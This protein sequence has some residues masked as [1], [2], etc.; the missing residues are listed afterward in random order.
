MMKEKQPKPKKETEPLPE[1]A[2][3]EQ[4]GEMV[5]L[6]SRMI[7]ILAE[8][9]TIPKPTTP[10]R[11]PLTGSIAAI[12]YDLRQ[13]ANGMTAEKSRDQA[14][15]AKADADRAELAAAKEKGLLMLV[16]D[17]K[18]IWSDGFV[19]IRDVIVRST[20]TTAQKKELSDKLQKIELN[21]A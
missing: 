14:R 20:L 8:K 21:E 12:V 13:Q 1:T 17:A 18:R 9:G 11:F 19:K 5:G 10:G 7:Y 4:I 2:T 16:A 3:A 6:T 15:Q